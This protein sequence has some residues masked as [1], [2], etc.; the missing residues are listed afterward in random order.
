[1]AFT[2]NNALK[3][4]YPQW[5]GA[6]GDGSTDD[7][8]AVQKA[9]DSIA[10]CNLPVWFPK[11]TYKV[12][13]QGSFISGR[14]STTY[15]ALKVANRVKLWGAGTISYSVANADYC[16]AICVVGTAG[17]KISRP[18]VLGLQ[19][20]GTG[21]PATIYA[22]NGAA[23]MLEYC[24]DALVRDVVVTNGRM[25][26]YF[27][28]CENSIMEN[29][30]SA[31]PAAAV[32]KTGNHF[33][34]YCCTTSSI[35]NCR[36]WGGMGDGDV[37]VFGTGQDNLVQG[38]RYHS[39]AKDDAAKTINYEN[40]QGLCIDAGPQKTRVV[41]NY[42]YGYAYGIDV[43]GGVWHTLVED[44]IVEKCWVGIAVRE[45]ET[46]GVPCYT[47]LVGND[48]VP[49]GGNGKTDAFMSLTFGGANLTATGIAATQFSFGV[50]ISGNIIANTFED[51]SN[52]YN[53]LGIMAY[54]TNT[55]YN[56]Y[57]DV[58]PNII[59]NMIVT[60]ACHSGKYSTSAWPALYLRGPDG[61]TY[62][63]NVNVN[64]NNIKTNPATNAADALVYAKRVDNLHFT[65]NILGNAHPHKG[66]KALLELNNC[67]FANIVGNNFGHNEYYKI[68]ANT[69]YQLII[70]NNT[71]G[72]LDAATHLIYAAS[73]E[74][75]QISNNMKGNTENYGTR[76][77]EATGVKR[78]VSLGNFMKFHDYGGWR[79]VETISGQ[80]IAGMTRANPCVVTWTDHGMRTGDMITFAGIT[81]TGWTALNGNVYPIT[82]L[83]ANT[84]SI[85]VNTTGYAADYNPGT[86]PGTYWFEA[87][88]NNHFVDY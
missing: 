43:K 46:S 70:Q 7:T 42:G 81:Q 22:Y 48:V 85:P 82:Y 3:E 83:S 57:H 78:I 6:A 38:C 86:D 21:T 20:A 52:S 19:F 55:D 13:R 59:G 62:L 33:H 49:N 63:Y 26:V 72:A 64:S 51:A 71:F 45:G 75:I 44:N 53:F 1:V 23:V 37:V 74:D 5:F 8:A 61:T 15:Y 56:N 16:A 27:V 80:Q 54:K 25:G 58:G 76:L 69:V 14:G 2:S 67:I 79:E 24:Q 41:G 12:T 34:L 73:V 31:C 28:S 10:G 32:P 60:Y 68:Y 50:N 40:A 39:Y 30:E 36:S 35:L 29:C 4:V 9:L 84:F 77:I 47:N 65:S 87:V 88:A 17:S 66:S 11:G 18:E